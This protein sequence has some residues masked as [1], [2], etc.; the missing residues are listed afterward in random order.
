MPRKDA[1][2]AMQAD[3]AQDSALIRHTAPYPCEHL[4][5]FPSGRTFEF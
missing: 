5:R 4:A 1:I 3:V 2:V